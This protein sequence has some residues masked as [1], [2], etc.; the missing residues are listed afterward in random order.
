V[1][2]AVEILATEIPWSALP[3]L[4]DY[5]AKHAADLWLNFDLFQEGCARQA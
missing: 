1:L 3:I 2:E 4:Q 5:H